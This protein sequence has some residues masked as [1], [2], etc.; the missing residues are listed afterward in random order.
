MTD[1]KTIAS[2]QRSAVRGSFATLT[3]AVITFPVSVVST[4]VVARALGPAP[5]GHLALLALLTG[6]L[7]PLLDFGFQSSFI[8]W[9]SA[10]EAAGD[11]AK[12]ALLMRQRFGWVLLSQAV[13]LLAVGPLVLHDQALWLQLAYVI[14]AVNSLVFSGTSLSLLVQNRTASAAAVNGIASVASALVAIPAAILT[15]S[16]SSV[17]VTRMLPGLLLVPLWYRLTDPRLRASVYRPAWPARLPTGY[18]RFGLLTWVA[19]GTGTLV[20]SRSEAFVMGFYGQ[21]VALGIFALAYGLSSQLTG[22]LDVLLSPLAPAMAGVAQVDARRTV[23]AMLRSTRFFALAAGALTALV[24]GI[25]VLV[26]LIYG[27]SYRQAAYLLLPLAA[28]STFQSTSNALSLSTYARR[29]GKTLAVAH[30]AALLVDVSLAFA[31]I[32]PLHAWG[33]VIA[34]AASQLVAIG[35]LLRRE[36]VVS[37]LSPAQMLLT[38]RAWACG[39]G[40][41][42]AAIGIG[43]AL[44]F[45]DVIRSPVLLIVGVSTYLL[46]VRATGGALEQRDHV[47]LAGA[48]PGSLAAAL[49]WNRALLGVRPASAFIAPL[50]AEAITQPAQAEGGIWE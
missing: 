32:P 5:F 33:A 19:V 41:A 46:F 25:A 10:A 4:I 28:V 1:N 9:A 30:A 44:P 31:L 3:S 35:W 42:G 39:I 21:G 48:L 17:W 18:W 47:A 20:F 40:A 6:T 34:N 45:A 43:T 13:P 29:D 8:Q 38:A 22:P 23:A 7:L 26:P 2:L 27:A 50:D 15:H 12:T 24:P 36:L 16:A 11:H 49:R 14:A 37:G